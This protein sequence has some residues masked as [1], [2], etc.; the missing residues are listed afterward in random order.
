MKITKRKITAATSPKLKIPTPFDKYYRL[1]SDAEFEDYTGGYPAHPSPCEE[2]KGY[3]IKSF[4]YAIAKPEYEDYLSNDGLD[5]VELVTSDWDENKLM[6]AYVV[7]DRVYPVSESDLPDDEEIEDADVYDR[8]YASERIASN[9]GIDISDAYIIYDWYDEEG[10]L[11][12]FDSVTAFVDY[13]SDD[14]YDMLDACDDEALKQRLLSAIEGCSNVTS[15]TDVNATSF[16]YER[17]EDGWWY[18]SKH[19]FGPGTIPSGVTV[20]DWY[21]DDRWNTWMLLDRVIT[22]QELNDYELKEQTPPEGVT[23]HNGTV[24]EGCSNIRASECKKVFEDDNAIRYIVSSSPYDVDEDLEF[25]DIDSANDIRDE[26]KPDWIVD[27]LIPDDPDYVEREERKR[28]AR[29][30]ADEEDYYDRLHGEGEY[31]GDPHDIYGAEEVEE[32]NEEGEDF[33]DQPDQEYSS[34]ET[35]INGKQGKLPAVFSKANIPDGALVLDYGGGTVE[36]E[37]VAQAYLDQFNAKE[38]LYDPFNQ[39]PEHNREVIKT[40]KSAGGADV[41]VCSN[42]LNVIKEQEVR[43]DLLNKIKK[44]LKSGA[45]AYISVYEGSGKDEGSA[46]QKGKSFQNNRKLSGYLEEVQSV[47]PDATRKGAVIIAPNTGSNSVAANTDLSAIDIDQLKADIVAGCEEYLT[48]PAGGFLPSGAPKTD[49]WDMTADE[50]YIVEVKDEP[51]DNRIE[52]EVR[53][54]LSYSGMMK[55]STVLDRIIAKYDSDAYFEM[56]EP[57]IMDA[58]IYGNDPIE[59]ATKVEGGSYDAIQRHNEEVVNHYENSRVNPPEYEDEDEDEDVL[60]PIT[61]DFDFDVKIRVY[62]DTDWEVTEGNLLSDADSYDD[63][64]VSDDTL[65]EDLVQMLTWHIPADEGEFNLKGKAHI[66]YEPDWYAL[67]PRYTFDSKRSKVTDVVVSPAGK[68]ESSTAVKAAQDIQAVM[69][70]EDL[71]Y[72]IENGKPFDLESFRKWKMPPV[73]EGTIYAKDVKVGDIISV[74][75]DA[76][77]VNLGTTVEI[78][79][80]NDP[81]ESWIEYTFKC[82]IVSDP[83]GQQLTAG[84]EIDLHFDGDEPIGPLVDMQ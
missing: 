66:V 84:D 78:L 64:G 12:D 67:S 63:M 60:D 38:M 39:T 70:E 21:E 58:Y 65:E 28:I 33:L 2:V 29:E 57:G 14:I 75:E 59:G 25:I 47:F 4:S 48:S 27:Y 9:L 23:T 74:E 26:E 83:G 44:L 50:I 49:K 72:A 62:E 79:A 69:T 77:E 37:Q 76:S 46:T 24:I 3:N 30:M 13:V 1:M 7:G 11:D 31:E 10:A 36:S 5:V 18:Y 17:P 54:E 61:L 52:V 80:I 15:S 73:P 22:T 8:D 19:G 43:I 40:L 35:A 20:L 81:A 16:S 55:M 68:V 53:A 56:V 45:N 71:D 32:D 6:L 41:A 34:A 82:K 42:V 51:Y